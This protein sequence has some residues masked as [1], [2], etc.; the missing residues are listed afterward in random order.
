M[1]S[2][3][4]LASVL[5]VVSAYSKCNPSDVKG[6]INIPITKVLSTTAIEISGNIQ[7]I[8]GCTVS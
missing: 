8:D 2:A 4:V 1:F 3:A 6:P 5:S 7:I